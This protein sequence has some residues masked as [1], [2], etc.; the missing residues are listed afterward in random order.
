MLAYTAISS[1]ED[2]AIRD[3]TLWGQGFS[4]P[5]PVVGFA[6]NGVRNRSKS[7]LQYRPEPSSDDQ[8]ETAMGELS[9]DLSQTEAETTRSS[10][11]TIYF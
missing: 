2:L 9:V 6:E 11:E 7:R 3:L 10:A 1:D 5:D 8:H 4:W